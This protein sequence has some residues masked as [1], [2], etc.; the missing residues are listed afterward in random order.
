MV[1]T[2]AEIKDI[3]EALFSWAKNTKNVRV[4][5][6]ETAEESIVRIIPNNPKSSGIEFRFGYYGKFDFGLGSGLYWEDFDNS[7]TLVIEICDAAKNGMIEEDVW[8]DRNG[9]IL[10]IEGKLTLS[11][12]TLQDSRSYTLFTVKKD[13]THKHNKFL[14][15]D[16]PPVV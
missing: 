4:E 11:E 15:F 3:H 14:P 12:R 10:K 16:S 9:K 7:K 8:T 5:S 6:E 2:I 1:N 13:I